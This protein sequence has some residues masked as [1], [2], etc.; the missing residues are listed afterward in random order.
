M[1]QVNRNGGKK[2]DKVERIHE[3]V[4]QRYTSAVTK[5]DASCCKPSCC[6]GAEL[7]Q[8][9]VASISGYRP[10]ELR[11]L[12]ADAVVNSFGCGNPLAFAGVLPGQTVI[13]I[14]SGAG[15]DCLLA[16]QKV[17]STGHVI[18]IDMTPKMIEKSRI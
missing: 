9:R 3:E 18:G 10:E 2:M 8:D 1:K 6:G 7:P 17:G 4:K 11:V 14:G 15:I 5:Q 12:P 13:D 16:S